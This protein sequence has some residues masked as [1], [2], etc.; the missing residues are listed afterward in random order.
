M[1]TQI[2][3]ISK[4]NILEPKMR[5]LTLLIPI[6]I[7]IS[8]CDPVPLP[9]GERT[10]DVPQFEVPPGFPDGSVAIGVNADASVWAGDQRN[11]PHGTE[12]SIQVK[13]F[14]DTPD[15]GWAYRRAF[16]KFEVEDVDPASLSA[17]HLALFGNLKDGNE[18]ITGTLFSVPDEADGWQEEAITWENQPLRASDLPVG[19]ISFDHVLEDPS[20]YEVDAEWMISTNLMEV[21]RRENAGNGILSL[22]VENETLDEILFF[23]QEHSRA[24]ETAPRLILIPLD[25]SP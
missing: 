17:V 15:W 13:T 24:E 12:P 14:E 22:R 3:Q 11:I 1:G 20:Q 6:F 2:A 19:S 9:S 23:A 7:F 18:S 10:Y 4:R 25:P 21:F 5:K 8:A 16:L